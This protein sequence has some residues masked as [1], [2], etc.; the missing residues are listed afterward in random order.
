MPDID[1]IINNLKERIQDLFSNAEHMAVEESDLRHPQ[2]GSIRKKVLIVD[3]EVDLCLLMKQ[4]FV[5]KK[6]E[7]YIAHT[8]KDALSRVGSINPH[9]ILL[10]PWLLSNRATCVQQLREAAPHAQITSHTDAFK[11]R[12]DQ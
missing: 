2:T 12:N 4:Y 1:H 6:F 10:D 11:K 8:C 9:F 7:V 3:D 5:R